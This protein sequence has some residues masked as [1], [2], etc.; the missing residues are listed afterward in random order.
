MNTNTNK[1]TVSVHSARTA[2]ETFEKRRSTRLKKAI[3][4]AER[5]IDVGS[6]KMAYLSDALTTSERA[7]AVKAA[8]AASTF[9]FGPFKV[10]NVSVAAIAVEAKY[11]RDP[12]KGEQRLTKENYFHRGLCMCIAASSRENVPFRSVDGLLYAK[13]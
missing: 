4:A 9:A 13:Q 2:A 3:A 5:G 8:M 11:Q 6:G 1:K 10:T 12:K 7:A